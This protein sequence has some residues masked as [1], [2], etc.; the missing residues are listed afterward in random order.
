MPATLEFLVRKKDAFSRLKDSV[1][2]PTRMPPLGA[3]A[4]SSSIHPCKFV[5]QKV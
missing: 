2:L 4:I 1:L 5:A 3:H